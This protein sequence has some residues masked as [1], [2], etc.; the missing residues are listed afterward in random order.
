M[1]KPKSR[2]QPDLKV[3]EDCERLRQENTRL[4]DA[5]E[6]LACRLLHQAGGKDPHVMRAGYPLWVYCI[7]ESVRDLWKR[8]SR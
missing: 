7:P 4:R 2:P 6:T 1:M 3:C 5:I 8:G